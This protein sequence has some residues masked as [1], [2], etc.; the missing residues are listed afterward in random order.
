MNETFTTTEDVPQNERLAPARPLPFLFVVLHNDNPTL[1]GARYSLLGIDEITIGRG[2][3]REA[4][5]ADEAGSRRLALRL[6]SSTVSRAHA[7]LV[8]SHDEWLLEDLDSKNGCCV[9]GER[10]TRAR[11]RDGDFVEIG[12]VVLRYR[13]ALPAPPGFAED[14]DSA[15]RPPEA[16]GFTTLVPAIAAGLGTLARIARLPISTLLLGETGTGKEVLAKGM[17]ALSGRPGPRVAVNCGGLTS[18]LVESQLFG[19]VK[20]AF[21]GAQRDEPG[22]IRSAD[23]GTLFLDE[24]GDLPLPAQAAI[25]RVLQ[26]REVVPVG[27]TRPTIVDVRVIAATHKSLDALCLRGEFRSDLLARIAGYQHMLPPLRERMEDVGLLISDLLRQMSVPGAMDARL[28]VTT[29][30]RL[31]SHAWHLNIRELKQ[32]LTLGVGLAERGVVEPLHLPEGVVKAPE[33]L[34][35]ERETPSSTDE[36]RE[37]LISLLRKH[38]GNVTAVSRTLGKSRIHIHRWMAKYG[39]D[40]DDYRG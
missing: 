30:R 16:S 15:L 8:R 19:H 4:S 6:P 34:G 37:Q 28:S 35:P 5:R 2:S 12:S 31:L 27:G 1:G 3:T 11:I 13:A 23:G 26:E 39:I 14:F 9:N 36:L 38:R 32:V 29:G 17:H 7:R 21:T 24:I 25:L 18:S 33:K 40:P 20:G 22:F 10:V